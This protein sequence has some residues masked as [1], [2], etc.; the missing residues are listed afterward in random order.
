M[1]MPKKIKNT[2]W[3]HL[4]MG[5]VL[6]FDSDDLRTMSGDT[7]FI[8]EL[9]SSGII[10]VT[11]DGSEL[12]FS[13][14]ND[15]FDMGAD[16]NIAFYCSRVLPGNA[17]AKQLTLEKLKKSTI[18]VMNF[19]VHNAQEYVDAPE[20]FFTNEDGSSVVTVSDDVLQHT[21]VNLS[22]WM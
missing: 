19:D 4:A 3:K 10:I 14:L 7:T 22:Y 9:C 6:T 2:E 1:E 15:E 21:A 17:L 11:E 13:F 18:L 20:L 12:H 16:G 5:G 8:Q